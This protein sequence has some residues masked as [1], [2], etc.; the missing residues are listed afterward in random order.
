M[1]GYLSSVSISKAD[2]ISFAPLESTSEL[3][4]FQELD[5]AYFI[6]SLSFQ[7][8]NKWLLFDGRHNI[9]AKI[10][11]S[12]FLSRVNEN[13]ELF[14]KGDQLLCRVRVEQWLDI[15][16]KSRI[17]NRI[18]RVIDHVSSATQPDLFRP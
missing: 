11:D 7:D 8:E 12:D 10:E 18:L 16:G 14:A 5:Q 1:P 17:E 15:N 6:N 9:W 2:L 4:T 3:I 13:I